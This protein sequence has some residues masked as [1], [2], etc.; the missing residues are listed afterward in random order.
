[1]ST[2]R[3]LGMS[4]FLV[5]L[6]QTSA[7]ARGIGSQ[8]WGDGLGD[9]IGSSSIS[10]WHSIWLIAVIGACWWMAFSEKSP[11]A[12]KGFLWQ[13]AIFLFGPAVTIT[14]IAWLFR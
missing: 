12:R 10:G 7:I 9:E 14:L 6:A 5:V 1:V 13:M 2:K 3:R 4:I 11:L 8:S